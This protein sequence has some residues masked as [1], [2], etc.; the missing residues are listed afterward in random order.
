MKCHQIFIST[1]VLGMM[2]DSDASAADTSAQQPAESETDLGAGSNKLSGGGRGYGLGAWNNKNNKSKTVATSLFPSMAR[3][4]QFVAERPSLRAGAEEGFNVRSNYPQLVKRLAAGQVDR[5]QLSDRTGLA[6][7][8]GMIDDPR[9]DF[10]QFWTARKK[11]ICEDKRC[12]D[13]IWNAGTDMLDM[14]E[15]CA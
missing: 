12:A 4:Q 1:N 2:S 3:H 14:M 6:K 15:D 10:E 7:R 9:N 11:Q 8:I 13:V 5:E